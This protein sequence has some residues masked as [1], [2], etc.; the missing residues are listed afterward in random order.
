MTG[1]WAVL[2]LAG[3]SVNQASVKPTS[4]RTTRIQS[5]LPSRG[6][7]VYYK[8]VPD[9]T[10]QNAMTR[11]RRHEETGTRQAHDFTCP[12]DGKQLI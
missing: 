6:H 8:L 4:I 12:R 2:L 1:Q 7:L 5:A 11:T 9:C 3:A 10:W